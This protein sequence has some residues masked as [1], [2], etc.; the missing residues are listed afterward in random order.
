MG[1]SVSDKFA[2]EV[3]CDL[4]LVSALES[5]QELLFELLQCLQQL[6]LHESVIDMCADNQTQ[7]CIYSSS[8]THP[9]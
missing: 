7:V 2:P 1:S 5:H 3:G 4:A 6:A 8:F 9:D